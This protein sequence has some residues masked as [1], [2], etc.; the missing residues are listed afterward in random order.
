MRLRYRAQALGDIEEIYRYLEQR[1]PS[2]A[3]N[4]LRAI[5]A[6]IQIVAERPYASQRT[7]DPEVRVKVMRRYGYKIFYR[8]VEDDTVEIM[9]VRHS[10]GRG[11]RR[12][13]SE[14][15]ACHICRNEIGRTKRPANFRIP[16]L[17]N[18]LSRL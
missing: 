11:Q 9:H 17:C 4:V 1:N 3:Q 7:D 18:L 13:V 5:Y 10:S 8:I 16:R 12:M 6:G 15:A 14:M 2:G